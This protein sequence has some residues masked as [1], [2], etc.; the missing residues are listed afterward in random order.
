MDSGITIQLKDAGKKFLKQWLF[1]NLNLELKQGDRLAITGL[2][3]S[4]KSTLLQILSG[5]VSLSEGTL[6]CK[7]EDKTI[8]IADWYRYITAAT[9]YL[10]IPEE[11]SLRE[12]ILFFA[13]HKKL[14]ESDAD[15]F[16]KIAGLEKFLD[17]P[18]KYFS[19]GMKQRVRL[20][21][22]LNADVPVV[23][24]DEPVSNLDRTGIEWFHRIV[25]EL[26]QETLLIICSNH[27]PEELALCTRQIDLSA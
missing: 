22:A 14:R 11:L 5:F 12:N 16:A 19:S 20:L 27:V 23:L 15:R 4:G 2:N 18:L 7:Q 10:D 21:F 1:R 26:P 24:L 8:E 9:P 6:T 13:A 17:K 3:G 25:K